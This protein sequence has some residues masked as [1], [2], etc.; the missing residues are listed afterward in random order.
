MVRDLKKRMG[1][2]F[3][4]CGRSGREGDALVWSAMS[5]FLVTYH[6]GGMPSDPAQMEQA[7]AAFGRWLAQ[8]GKAVVD[9][10]TPLRSGTQVSNGAASPPVTIAGYSVIEAP[11]LQ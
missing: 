3:R 8:A 4:R 9:P 1:Q 5:R 7:K 2:I 10:G 11:D 6:G